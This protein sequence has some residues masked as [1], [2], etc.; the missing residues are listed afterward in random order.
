[1]EFKIGDKVIEIGEVLVTFKAKGIGT[2]MQIDSMGPFPIVV[3]FNN[4]EIDYTVDGKRYN[5]SNATGIR[6]LTPLE[7]VML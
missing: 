6:L 5:S 2:V 1:M 3:K 7:L 4:G